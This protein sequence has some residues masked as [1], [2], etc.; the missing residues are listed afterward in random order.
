MSAVAAPGDWRERLVTVL[1]SY[2]AVLLEHP[3]LA[4]SALV[5]RPSGPGYL[6]LLEGVLALL[7]AAD[8]SAA[9]A[10]WAVDLLALRHLTATEQGIRG[11]AIDAGDEEARVAATLLDVSADEYPHVA[12]IGAELLSG[13]GP[14][15]LTWGFNVLINGVLETP[16]PAPVAPPDH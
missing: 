8:L 1:W 14:D 5:T 15:R 6:R 11:R 2:T 3:G 4:Q 9:R 12:A 16:R 10:A 7:N 13:E